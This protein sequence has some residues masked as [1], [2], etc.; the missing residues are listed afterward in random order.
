MS[1][2]K[3]TLVRMVIKLPTCG[4][5]L[6]MPLQLD[7]VERLIDNEEEHKKFV[8]LCERQFNAGVPP[9]TIYEISKSYSLILAHFI[10]F[11]LLTILC[12]SYRK[13]R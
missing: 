4:T 1:W 10:I 12:V 7:F 6:N 13:A 5:L 11:Q 3:D 8:L 2:K 9:H